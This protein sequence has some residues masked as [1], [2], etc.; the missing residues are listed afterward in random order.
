MIYFFIY[1]YLGLVVVV[2]R[3]GYPQKLV[4]MSRSNLA[5][6]ESEARWKSLVTA[7]KLQNTTIHD[8]QFTNSA[9]TMGHMQAI[10]CRPIAEVRGLS[11]LF[12]VGRPEFVDDDSINRA[13]ILINERDSFQRYLQYLQEQPK[14]SPVTEFGPW[15]MIRK[16]HHEIEP[17][18]RPKTMTTR[19][20]SQHPAQ[21]TTRPHT[22][23]P[24]DLSES[25]SLPD[26]SF[27]T[28]DSDTGSYY[29]GGGGGKEQERADGEQVVNLVL[30]QFFDLLT[31]PYQ[32]GMFKYSY[33]R[34]RFQVRTLDENGDQ[35]KVFEA[36]TDGVCMDSS[37]EEIWLIFEAKAERQFEDNNDVGYAIQETGELA[38]V[39][40]SHPP[41]DL[42][43]GKKNPYVL[44]SQN[45]DQIWVTL[46]KVDKAYVDFITGKMRNKRDPK[47]FLDMTTIGPFFTKNKNHIKDLSTFVLAYTLKRMGI[48][49]LPWP[50]SEEIE[51]PPCSLFR[52]TASESTL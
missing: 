27:L 33:D 30:V 12:E 34:K 52:H 51:L 14:R 37:G 24:A 28:M 7:Y 26:I 44:I 17:E 32:G 50:E 2:F 11:K 5:L 39:V 23:E 31:L 18:D 1:V 46:A 49:G 22:P 13:R 38:A 21:P 20:Q 10:L 41:K 45:M 36:R 42:K 43:P 25:S 19:S 8:R 40:S 48:L 29:A 6:P 9:S 3:L 47:S 16:Y 4:T 35:V 15:T